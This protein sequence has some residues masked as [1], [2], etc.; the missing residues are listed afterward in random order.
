MK[1]K[2]TTK[3]IFSFSIILLLLFTSLLLGGDLFRF[4]NMPTAKSETTDICMGPY[5][6]TMD[7][8]KSE[9]PNNAYAAKRIGHEIDIPR[10]DNCYDIYINFR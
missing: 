4:I 3:V 5:N 2:D 6:V 9:C 10:C 7:D 8:P 1:K